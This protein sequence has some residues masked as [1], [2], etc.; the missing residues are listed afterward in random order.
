MII[1]SLF[2]G[3]S[4]AQQAL[5]ELGVVVNRYYA[6]EIDKYEFVGVLK[7]IIKIN[8]VKLDEKAFPVEEPIMTRGFSILVKNR[9]I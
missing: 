4:A 7:F 1:L 6:S 8:R 5:K 2:D 3:M 9:N